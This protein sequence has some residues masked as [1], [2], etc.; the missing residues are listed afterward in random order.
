[1][2]TGQLKLNPGAAIR[3]DNTQPLP[4]PKSGRSNSGPRMSFTDIFIRRPVLATS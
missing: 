2:T 3:I 1:M 4:G